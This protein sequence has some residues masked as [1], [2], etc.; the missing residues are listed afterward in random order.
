MLKDAENKILD[1]IC[2]KYCNLIG[3]EQVP[4]KLHNKP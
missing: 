3:H 4:F 2:N 1:P